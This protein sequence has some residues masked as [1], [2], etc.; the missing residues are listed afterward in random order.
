[1][2]A[3]KF[4]K[5]FA[6]AFR[7]IITAVRQE[8]NARVHLLAAVT[9]LVLGV[10]L[11]VSRFEWMILVL[12]I[13]GVLAAELINSSI[14]ELADLYSRE[15][16]PSIEKIKDLAAGAVLVAAITALIVGL[17]IFLPKVVGH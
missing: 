2:D 12:V 15:Y 8:P 3:G 13:G 6:Y 14:E 9:V 10:V 11:D 1:M 5:G 7:G 16:H 4:L 17:I